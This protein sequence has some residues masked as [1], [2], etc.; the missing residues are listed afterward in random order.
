[1]KDLFKLIKDVQFGEDK[2]KALAEFIQR[3]NSGEDID[4]NLIYQLMKMFE[5]KS[6]IFPNRTC[7]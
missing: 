6:Q 2:D 4:G 5:I 3:V 7:S 1:M